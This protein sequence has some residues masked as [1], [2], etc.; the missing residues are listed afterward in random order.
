MQLR[1]SLKLYLVLGSVH[2]RKSPI[3][4]LISAIEGGI[5]MFQ[6]REKGSGSLQCRERLMLGHALHALCKMNRIPFIVN[7]DVELAI[8]LDADGIHIGQEDTPIDVI[9]PLFPNKLIGIS[10]H[11]AEEARKAMDQGADYIGVGPMYPTTTKTDARAVQGSTVI[12]SIRREGINLP[13]V[14][15]GGIDLGRAAPLIQ[16]GADGIAVVSAITQAFRS[17]LAAQMLLEEITNTHQTN[18]RKEG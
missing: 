12:T 3:E 10:V 1:E 13:L 18:K 17:D 14:A 11:N 5:T 8:E 16:V 9:R 2:C 7:D 6:Y 15:I 4:V